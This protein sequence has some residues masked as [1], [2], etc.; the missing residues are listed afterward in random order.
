MKKLLF[1]VSIVLISTTISCGGSTG[2]NSEVDSLT[3][4]DTLAEDTSL[5]SPSTDVNEE[6][7]STDVEGDGIARTGG[8]TY[9]KCVT[10]KIHGKPYDLGIGM[11]EGEITMKCGDPDE[12]SRS[13]DNVSTA[14]LYYDHSKIQLFIYDGELTQVVDLTK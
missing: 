1:F 5:S 14:I 2:H 7:N 9:P 6:D 8:Y 12:I 11:S 3:W 4:A 10:V 13:R